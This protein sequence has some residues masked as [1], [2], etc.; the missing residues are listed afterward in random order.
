MKIGTR[1]TRWHW[2]EDWLKQ[3]SW[4]TRERYLLLVSSGPATF[5]KEKQEAEG[6]FLYFE[7][8]ATF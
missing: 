4:Y 2:R 5:I 3:K 1:L 6:L 8:P 7:N